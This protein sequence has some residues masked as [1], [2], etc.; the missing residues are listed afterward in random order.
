VIDHTLIGP[1]RCQCGAVVFHVAKC[2]MCGGRTDNCPRAPMF[3]PVVKPHPL[4]QSEMS[5][6][7]QAGIASSKLM[8]TNAGNAVREIRAARKAG[9]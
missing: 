8:R 7:V 9:R 4:P 5:K 1:R 2:P 3:A 6:K